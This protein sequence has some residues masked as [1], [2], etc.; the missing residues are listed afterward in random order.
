M[1][2]LKEHFDYL[3]D[4]YNVLYTIGLFAKNNIS[5]LHYAIKV[6]KGF[7]VYILSSD[8]WM[9]ENMYHR[10]EDHT[11]G[12]LLYIYMEEIQMSGGASLIKRL[13]VYW[14]L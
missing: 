6:Y 5:T 11:H 1:G 3:I 10:Y 8:N 7:N 14:K 4:K 2:Y 9:R 13:V 12:I